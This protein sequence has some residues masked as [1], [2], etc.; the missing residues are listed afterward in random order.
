MLLTLLHWRRRRRRRRQETSSISSQ[1][2][3]AG[4]RDCELDAGTAL[5]QREAGSSQCSTHN[6][7][8]PDGM[9]GADGNNGDKGAKGDKGDKGDTGANGAAGTVLRG[10]PYA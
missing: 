4:V 6:E 1:R 8:I 2:E 3:V 7:F 9:D 10:C 5:R